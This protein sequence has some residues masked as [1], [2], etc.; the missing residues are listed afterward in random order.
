MAYRN[1]I[2]QS[3]ASN[4]EV[5]RRFRD[6]LCKRNNAGYWDYSTSGIGWTLHDAVYAVDENTISNNDYFVA[7]SR[8]EDNNQDIY[9]KCTFIGTGIN[10]A[11]FLYWNATTHIGTTTYYFAGNWPQVAATAATLW[12]YGDLDSVVPI[13]HYNTT[14]YGSFFGH[15]PESQFA[16]TVATSSLAVSAGSNVVV[17]LSAVPSGWVV[18]RK[19]FIR[20]NANIE[21]I[22]ITNINGVNVTF[23]SI[24]ASYSAGCKFQGEVSYQVC[25]GGSFSGSTSV[26]FLKPM[27]NIYGVNPT[28][29]TS[30]TSVLTDAAAK[31][32][33][34][35]N[36]SGSY[37]V[38]VYEV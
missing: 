9:M 4:T 19:V 3:C 38:L 17:A 13:A 8:G 18:G 10:I 7:Y 36:I 14:T 23:S 16:T 2:S 21:R 25:G 32:Y 29:L 34:F 33:R 30:R 11:G 28:N 1:L 26:S 12:V 35:F 15:M 27:K 24:V 31:S 22:T 5:F 6:F 37:P 20:D